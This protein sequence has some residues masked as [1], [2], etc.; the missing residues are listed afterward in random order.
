ML[1]I[2]GWNSQHESQ[3]ERGRLRVGIPKPMA[4]ITWDKKLGQKEKKRKET[5]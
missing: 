4:G 5:R 3:L 2:M 1:K